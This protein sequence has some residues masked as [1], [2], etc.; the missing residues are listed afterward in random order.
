M[1][2]LECGGRVAANV[3]GGDGAW[4]DGEEC[5]DVAAGCVQVVVDCGQ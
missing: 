4:Y 2:L 1:G 3:G 5:Q